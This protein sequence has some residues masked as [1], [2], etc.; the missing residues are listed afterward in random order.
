MMK[1]R[2]AKLYRCKK[3]YA[4]TCSETWNGIFFSRTGWSVYTNRKHATPQWIGENFRRSLHTSEDFN[5]ASPL[6]FETVK[7]VN[8]ETSQANLNFWGKVAVDFQI[9][10]WRTAVTKTACVF[11]CW[12]YE[13]TDLIEL[14]ASRGGGGGHGAWGLDENAGKVFHVSIH[15]TDEAIGETILKAF[16]A[17]RPHYA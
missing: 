15:D 4:V 10:D 12:D 16:N 13:N 2:R 5:Q 17:C 6:S 8:S 1:T 7:K 3:F 11:S 9:K 14:T